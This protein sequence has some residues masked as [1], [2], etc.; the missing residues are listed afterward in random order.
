[1]PNEL[2]LAEA[3]SDW[4]EKDRANLWT[5][6]TGKNP[7]V[8]PDASRIEEKFKW[9]YHSKMRT[10]AK[11]GIKNLASLAVAK[12]R[13]ERARTTG[14]EDEHPTPTYSGL[15]VAACKF[16]KVY[17]PAVAERTLE[18]YLS[19]EVI[20]A[21]LAAM[22]AADRKRFFESTVPVDELAEEAGVKSAKVR[23]PATT[24]VALGLAQASGFGVY[25][26][27]TTALGFLTHAVGVTLPFA[28]YTGMTSTIAFV[29]GPAG[30]IG[31]GLWAA[32][33]LTGPEWKRLVPAL[34]YIAATNARRRG[35]ADYRLAARLF[36]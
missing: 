12:A 33:R 11:V 36:L 27:A 25:L 23:G 2:T 16:R 6:L 5:L 34:L 17:D 7:Q 15:L 35:H 14:M 24:F 29:I 22:K 20:A 4:D 28:V 26:A 1:M 32:W 9:A 10:G 3:L 21:A 13:G 19:Q 18:L 8:P 31:A 30:W